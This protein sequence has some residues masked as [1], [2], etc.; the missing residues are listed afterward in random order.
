MSIQSKNKCQ[1]ELVRD[2]EADNWFFFLEGDEKRAQ[3]RLLNDIWFASIYRWGGKEKDIATVRHFWDGLKF[4]KKETSAHLVAKEELYKQL[5][6]IWG[7]RKRDFGRNKKELE[8][9]ILSTKLEKEQ[10]DG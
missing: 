9:D 4:I 10:N 3:L 7:H 1:L 6:T 2:D 5:Y 8:S